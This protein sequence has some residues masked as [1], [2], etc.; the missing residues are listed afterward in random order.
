MSGPF[1]IIGIVIIFYSIVPSNLVAGELKLT[2]EGNFREIFDSGLRPIML[3]G[4]SNRS[5]YVKDMSISL[6]LE[7]HV[8]PEV[9]AKK[10]DIG[11]LKNHLMDEVVVF[12]GEKMSVEEARDLAIKWGVDEDSLGDSNLE[13]FG[14]NLV[15]KN[16]KWR[17]NAG[18]V[19]S[20]NEV[21]PLLFRLF[22]SW[23][24][25]FKELETHQGL[26][27]PPPGYEHVSMEE[28]TGDPQ[29]ASNPKAPL[30]NGNTRNRP[31]KLRSTDSFDTI[32]GNSKNSDVFPWWLIASAFAIFVLALA[33]WLKSRKSKSTP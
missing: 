10:I 29:K 30:E 13:N 20:Y 5:C 3:G 2:G 26:L 25:P 24:R 7:G 14:W 11:V 15:P 23:K 28:V 9:I 33:A 21:K 31:E 18:F 4:R 32:S 12:V 8:F 1:K 17:A 16:D 27:P 22:I 19:S 6:N